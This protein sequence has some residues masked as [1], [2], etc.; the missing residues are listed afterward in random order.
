LTKLLGRPPSTAS[1][2]CSQNYTGGDAEAVTG[3]FKTGRSVT[4]NV[5]LSP[6]TENRKLK[7][8]SSTTMAER[9]TLTTAIHSVPNADP[10]VVRAFVTQD[11][12]PAPAEGFVAKCDDHRVAVGTV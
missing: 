3:K 5:H 4:L 2:G 12:K 8:A 9:R 6:P 7:G 10:E 11:K 1:K